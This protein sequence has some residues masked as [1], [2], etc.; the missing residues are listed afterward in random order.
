MLNCLV[1][2]CTK[3]PKGSPSC[4]AKRVKIIEKQEIM[5][6][7]EVKTFLHQTKSKKGKKE[8]MHASFELRAW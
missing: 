1:N 3:A 4:E 2:K 8:D 5:I 7:T 6:L